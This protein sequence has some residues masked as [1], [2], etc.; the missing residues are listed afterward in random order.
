MGTGDGLNNQ[1][2]S[3]K[4][5]AETILAHAVVFW[6]R[7]L[8]SCSESEARYCGPVWGAGDGKLGCHFHCK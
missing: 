4:G 2:M 3:N 5:R 6:Q 7:L 8:T 1:M